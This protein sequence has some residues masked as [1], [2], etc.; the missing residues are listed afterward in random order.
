MRPL[1]PALAFFVL[2]LVGDY[3]GMKR[4]ED[5]SRG[6]PDEGALR[7]DR[8]RGGALREPT[9]LRHVRNDRVGGDLSFL[10]GDGFEAEQDPDRWVMSSPVDTS[11]VTAQN[12][13]DDG[14]VVVDTQRSVVGPQTYLLRS[15]P[16][17]TRSRP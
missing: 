11:R 16:R 7:G 6:T 12:V 5:P 9:G 3:G 17:W 1:L 8:G 2:G 13:G 14:A 15:A 4:G 10:L